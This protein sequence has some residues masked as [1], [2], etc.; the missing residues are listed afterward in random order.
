MVRP[1]GTCN[2]RSTVLLWT[3]S[4]YEAVEESAAGVI[5]ESGGVGGGRQ[6]AHRLAGISA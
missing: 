3:P 1:V 6:T 5:Q 4:N 2:V